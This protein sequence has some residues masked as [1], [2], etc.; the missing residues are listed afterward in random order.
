MPSPKPAQKRWC[1]PANRYQMLPE[2]TDAAND[3]GQ[4]K[5]IRDLERQ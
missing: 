4:A 1:H 3:S 5:T 2:N